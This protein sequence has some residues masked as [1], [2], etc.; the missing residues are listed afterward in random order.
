M[1][2]NNNFHTTRWGYKPRELDTNFWWW[3][4]GV[5]IPC[6]GG[7]QSKSKKDHCHIW[8]SVNFLQGG[9]REIYLIPTK[10]WPVGHKIKDRKIHLFR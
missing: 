8:W 2:V 5:A 4:A 7:D 10:K 6:S 3:C 1:N 9:E